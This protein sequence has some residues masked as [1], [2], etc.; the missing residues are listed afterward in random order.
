MKMKIRL[1]LREEGNSWNAY[2]ALTDTMEGAKL[3]GSIAAGAIHKDPE[4]KN[5]FMDLM[6]RVLALAIKETTG[7]APDFWRT[8][9]APESERGG[10]A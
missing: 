6:K 7:E 1:A 10:N 9:P 5:D 3:I 2:M 8:G 4:I